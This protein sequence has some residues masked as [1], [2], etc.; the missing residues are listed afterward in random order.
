MLP[1]GEDSEMLSCI[2]CHARVGHAHHS[3]RPTYE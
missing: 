1:S 2:H 3:A